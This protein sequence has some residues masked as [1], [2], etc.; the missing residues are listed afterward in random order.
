MSSHSALRG[1]AKEPERQILALLSTGLHADMGRLQGLGVPFTGEPESAGPVTVV[2]FSDPD[3][4][5]VQL[6]QFD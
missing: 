3:G 2:T 4:N 6:I 1:P 5:L